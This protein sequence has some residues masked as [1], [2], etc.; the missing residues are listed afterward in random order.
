MSFRLLVLAFVAVGALFADYADYTLTESL[1]DQ[2]DQGKS[3]CDVSCQTFEFV[4]P[5]WS[6]YG[7]DLP[8]SPAPGDP[9]AQLDSVEWTFTDG[10]PADTLSEE[11]DYTGSYAASDLAPY[12]GENDF[13][14]LVTPT[15][16]A[17]PTLSE[18]SPSP[19]TSTRCRSQRPTTDRYLP[20]AWQ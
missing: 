4:F 13:A 11:V 1:V 9:I 12:L 19:L 15:D 6:P 8:T 20:R 14:I 16:P 17:P 18:R 5:A 2:G 7:L 3:N 10:N